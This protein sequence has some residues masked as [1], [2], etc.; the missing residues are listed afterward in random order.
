[1]AKMFE[2]KLRPVGNSLGFIVPKDI[3][4]DNGYQRGDIVHVAIPMRDLENRNEKLKRL[5]G[6]YSGKPRFKREK[7]DRF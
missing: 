2:A 6:M 5:A 1:M 7:G 3:I 4:K